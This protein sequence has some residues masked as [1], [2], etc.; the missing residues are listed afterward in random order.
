[1]GPYNFEYPML[2][3][4]SV[5]KKGIYHFEILGK[6]GAWKLSASKGFSIFNKERIVY[7]LPFWRKPT[8]L[9]KNVL[10]N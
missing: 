5:D 2:W 9:F 3:L 10:L 6:H 1:M 8:P 4:D 7:L